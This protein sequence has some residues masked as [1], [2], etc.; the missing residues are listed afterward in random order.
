MVQRPSPLKRKYSRPR[1]G[2]AGPAD[3]GLAPILKILDAAKLH[4]GLM[5]V[6]PVAGERILALDHEGNGEEIAV[7]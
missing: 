6:D 4:A 7:A 3:E 5:D 1:A 2:R